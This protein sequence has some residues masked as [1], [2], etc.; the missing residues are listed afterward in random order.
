MKTRD[1]ILNIIREQE[2]VSGKAIAESIGI[3]RQAVNKHIQELLQAGLISISGRTR[4]ALYHVPKNGIPEVWS[5]SLRRTY[6]L[7]GLAEDRV[8]SEISLLLGLKKALTANCL[9]IIRYAF[10]E[11]LNNAIEHSGSKRCAIRVDIDH[12]DAAFTIRDFGI[13]VFASIAGK[14]KL[15]DETQAVGELIKGK[16]TTLPEKHSGEGIFFT[17]KCGD[18]VAFRS[19]KINLLFDNPSQDVFVEEKRDFS[20]TEAGFT[21]RRNSRR[22]LSAVFREYAPE[23]YDYR[24]E[25]TRVYV[26]LFQSG[27]VSRSEARRLLSGLEVFREIILDFKGVKSLGQGFADEIF[28]VF[29][30]AHP[31]IVIIPENLSSTLKLMIDHVR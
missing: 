15:A 17:A 8:F 10:T 30:G 26:R 4:G 11:L 7:E 5:K 27:Y 1:R 13:G 6:S 21:I 18:K 14:F 22:K 19:H 20:G 9:E 28:R 16:R 24:F 25:K 31:D 23:D 2:P 29:A 3:T 12:R